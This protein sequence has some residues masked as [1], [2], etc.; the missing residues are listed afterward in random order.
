MDIH[1]AFFDYLNTYQYPLG[2]SSLF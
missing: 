1:Q 2:D